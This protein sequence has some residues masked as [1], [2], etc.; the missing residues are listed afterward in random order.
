MKFSMRTLFFLPPS[1]D[2]DPVTRRQARQLN[3]L[4]WVNMV[5]AL[6]LIIF[7]S[8]T[9][10]VP[11]EVDI[12]NLILIG[13]MFLLRVYMIYGH[14]RE[15]SY[16]LIVLQ[17]VSVTGIAFTEYLGTRAF[18]GF[19]LVVVTSAL[20]STPPMSML[21]I[22]LSSLEILFLTQPHEA[23]TFIPIHNLAINGDWAAHTIFLCW[24]GFFVQFTISDLNKSVSQAHAE[25]NTRIQIEEA[26]RASEA[27]LRMLLE[28]LGEGVLVQDATW[29]YTYANPA[30]HQILGWQEGELVSQS[31]EAILHPEKAQE[32]KRENLARWAGKIT[33]YETEIVR[34]DGRMRTLLTT[35][36]PRLDEQG[37]LLETIVAFTDITERKQLEKD[38]QAERD[39]VLQIINTM[40][41]GVTVLN[42]LGRFVLVNPAFLRMTGYEPDELLGHR[43]EEVTVFEDQTI[44]QKAREARRQGKTTTYENRLRH[45]KGHYVPVLITGVPR[46]K[47]DAYGGAISVVTDLT[48][49]KRNEEAL[50]TAAQQ[51]SERNA[52][53]QALHEINLRLH[54]SKNFAEIAQKAVEGL[55]AYTQAE[56]IALYELTQEENAQFKLLAHL[57][58]DEEN[59]ARASSTSGKGSLSQRSLESQKVLFSKDLENDERATQQVRALLAKQG[60]QSAAFVPLVYQEENFGVVN[61][62]FQKTPAYNENFQETLLAIGNTVGLALANAKHLAQAQAE[63]RER[64]RIEEEIR[65]LNAELEKRVQERTTQLEEAN[66]ELESFAYS[67]SHDLR[68]PLRAIEGFVVVLRETKAEQLDEEARHYLSRIIENS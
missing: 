5:A 49:L 1:L 60:F 42:E 29:H 57:G 56:R 10:N 63:T 33:T 12:N 53:L 13:V 46:W 35:G 58:F 27:R 36:V 47:N 37:K 67:V 23:N 24:I 15:A 32:V 14:V 28:N 6:I 8:L 59:L 55:H 30:A 18:Y 21:T 64:R 45:K 9:G 19:Y 66:R 62:I 2:A 17:F 4:I 61:L 3:A 50:L 65:Q 43:P 41:Q 34:P 11:I 68:S 7:N 25:L 51:L 52:S 40:G 48:E 16:A 39:F 26:L 38:L 20:L 54:H 44:L 22:A 31:E